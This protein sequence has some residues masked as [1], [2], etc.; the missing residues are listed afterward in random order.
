MIIWQS[1]LGYNETLSLASTSLIFFSRFILLSLPVLLYVEQLL[2]TQLQ[3]IIKHH[4]EGKTKLAFVGQVNQ[5]ITK[6]SCN[7]L[8]FQLSSQGFLYKKSWSPFF[9]R[10]IK[11]INQPRIDILEHIFPFYN[12]YEDCQVVLFHASSLPKYYHMFIHICY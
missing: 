1:T 7:N 4:Y 9:Q 6:L 11:Y 5:L 10:N 2:K 12:Q 3:E 8:T